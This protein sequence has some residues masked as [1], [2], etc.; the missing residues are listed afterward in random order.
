MNDNEGFENSFMKI[1]PKELELKNAN[2]NVIIFLD[3]NITIKEGQFSTK[4]FDKRAG[5][6]IL[7]ICFL[8]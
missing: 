6:L 4:L 8:A 5:L 3:L 7:S 1:Y 2:G